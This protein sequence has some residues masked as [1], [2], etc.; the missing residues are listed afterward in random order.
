MA[1]F[2]FDS[3]NAVDNTMIVGT[4]NGY[5]PSICYPHS[6]SGNTM[7]ICYLCI[8]HKSYSGLLKGIQK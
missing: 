1:Y 5:A 7:M 4:N 8:M 6:M 2:T 3:I